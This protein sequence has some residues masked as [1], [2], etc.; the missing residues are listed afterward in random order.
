MEKIGD[1]QWRLCH[2]VRIVHWYLFRAKKGELLLT[3]QAHMLLVLTANKE[4][5][6]YHVHIAPLSLSSMDFHKLYLIPWTF[7]TNRKKIIVFFQ[8]ERFP[9]RQPR[10]QWN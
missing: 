6:P 1:P 8:F 9:S 10:E 4:T 3:V 5:I 2:K 7:K